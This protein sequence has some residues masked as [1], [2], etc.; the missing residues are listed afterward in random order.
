[1]RLAKTK[2]PL[3]IA[4]V[5]PLGKRRVDARPSFFN[6]AKLRI[7]GATFTQIARGEQAKSLDKVQ[8]DNM[9]RR[10]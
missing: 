5:P 7:H 3:S 2:S 8:R 6:V 9:L 4:H 10:Q 1:M